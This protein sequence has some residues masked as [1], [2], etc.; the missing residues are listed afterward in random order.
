MRRSQTLE[1]YGTPLEWPYP[2]EWDQT[3]FL[4]TDVLVLGGGI[5]GCWAAI[6]AAR[7]GADVV[8]VEKAAT[9]RS[10]AGGSGCDHW[11]SAATNPCSRITPEELT[12]ALIRSHGGYCNGISHYIECREGYDRLLDLEQMG[13]KIRDTDDEFAGA[14]F[15]DEKTRLLFAYDYL[16]RFTLRVW[17]TTFKPALHEENRRLGVRVLDRT[18]ATSLLSEGGRPGSRVV[19][20]TAIHTR[21]GKFLVIDAK[22]TVLCMSRPSRLWLFS[23]KLPG[24]SEFRPPQCNGD[25]H[26]MAWRAGAEF[27]MMEKSVQA[28]WSGTRS[29]PPYG[30][31][32]T[33][34]TWYACSMVDANGREIP[35]A[36]RD[37]NILTEVSQRYRP[38]P[39]QKLYLKGGCE[40]DLPSYEFQGP[41]ILPVSELLEQGYE[42][43]F[44]ADLPSMPELERRAIWGLMVGQE[45]KTKIPIL[46]SYSAAGFDPD[47]DL[48]QSYGE[49]WR[50]ASYLP[51]ERQL[52]GYPGGLVN[53]WSLRTNL[54]GLYA[55]GDQ[56]F[57]SN[58]HGH[59]AATGHYAGRHAASYA[60]SAPEVTIDRKQVEGERSRI[61]SLLDGDADVPWQELNAAISWVMRHHCGAVKSADLLSSGLATLRELEQ[62]RVPRLRAR[63]PRELMRA[64]EVLNVLTNAELVLHACL[65]RRAS[66]KYLLF[67]R[68]DYPEM[69]PPEWHKLVTVRL[70]GGTVVGG[71]GSGRVVEGELPI[72]Y[73]G[74]LPEGY[75]A[76]NE[77]YA[78]EVGP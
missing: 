12:D 28:E 68:S 17:G 75:E 48:L 35:W 7:H 59:A 47:Q 14:E 53:D 1:A 9:V 27:T 31:G 24:V 3:A 70:E 11:E 69:D 19:G 52:F 16:N 45:G 54:E 42:L 58:C 76:H 46:Q 2:V 30:T 65:A 32:N 77:G 44:F 21:T 73:Y 74:S 61:Y 13:G 36:D 66:A 60:E 5:A 56:L 39:G 8:L 15:R 55:A 50:S 10:G 37:G 51:H 33:H 67:E 20:A 64:L 78:G 34:N 29:H 22:A 25:G 49:G 38:A 40:P 23:T 41:D 72:D 57:A 63:N 6:A 62:S 71:D 4:S 26:A 43:P 18:M